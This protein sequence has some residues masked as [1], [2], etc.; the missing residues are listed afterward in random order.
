MIIKGSIVGIDSSSE[1]IS[2][3]VSVVDP[4]QSQPCPICLDE[5]HR[6][7][8]AKN[9]TV[10]LSRCQHFMHLNCLNELILS[11][12]SDVQKVRTLLCNL[13]RFQIN[14]I[15]L[16]VSSLNV[17]RAASFTARSEETNRLGRWVGLR[18][19]SH[20]QDTKTATRFRSFTSKNRSWIDLDLT[21]HQLSLISASLPA[22][23]LPIT[24]TRAERSLLL[25]SHA[26]VIYPRT[27]PVVKSCASSKSDSIV[28]FSSR[29]DVP[30]PPA[31]KT[32]WS[33]R[34]SS[35]RHNFRCTPIRRI[36]NGAWSS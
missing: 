2:R 29:L 23:K 5:L 18:F 8:S 10:S 35:T 33:G 16:R 15:I 21:A 34:T 1:Q 9:P 25:A 11:Q 12:K 13:A 6:D 36:C 14:F 27:P 32:S 17:P 19:R 24:P 26:C 28:G 31:S 20:C 22:L 4:P 30:Q 7:N 3:F